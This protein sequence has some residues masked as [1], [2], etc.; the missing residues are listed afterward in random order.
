MNQEEFWRTKIANDLSAAWEKMALKQLY[1]GELLMS[2]V[3]DFIKDGN[4]E[5][6][7]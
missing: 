5:T 3:L 1:S 7:Q 2:I 4:R 6:L